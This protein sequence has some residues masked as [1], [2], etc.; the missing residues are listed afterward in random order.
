MARY[1]KVSYCQRVQVLD[2]DRTAQARAETSMQIDFVAS[3][4]HHLY[5]TGSA[6]V[7][8]LQSLRACQHGYRGH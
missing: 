1:L 4:Q 5:I 6:L 8:L 2:N 7:T 3:Q